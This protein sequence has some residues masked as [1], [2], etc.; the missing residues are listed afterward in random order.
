MISE[1]KYNQLVIERISAIMKNKQITQTELAKKSNIGQSTLSKLLTNEAKITIQHIYK[2]CSALNVDPSIILSFE[3]I[4]VNYDKRKPEK[5]CSGIF[6]DNFL[7][8]SLFITNPADE[9]FNGYT[10]NEY[11]IYIYPT[12]STENELLHGILSLKNSEDN[13]HCNVIFTLFTGQS[14]NGYDITKKYL[15]EMIISRPMSACYIYLINKE[16]G[17][18]CFISFKHFYIFNQDLVCRVATISST[19]SGGNK[20]PVIQRALISKFELNISNNQTDDT[21]FIMGQLRLNDTDIIINRKQYENHINNIENDYYSEDLKDFFAECEEY[22]TNET[23]AIIDEQKIRS[24]NSDIKIKA[25][26]ISILRKLS[27][28]Q[29]YNK[30]SSKTDEFTFNYIKRNY[31]HLDKAPR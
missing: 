25:Q 11:H 6:K 13:S 3:D 14:K 20:L 26:A 8:S 4:E 27:I 30:V 16:I 5:P 24:I 18:M 28:A 17:E 10:N 21:Q 7:D 1:S 29:K 23:F 19:S 22:I 9:A 15:G 2:L 12:I 31:E